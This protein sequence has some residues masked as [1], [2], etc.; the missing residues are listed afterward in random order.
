MIY[1]PAN[2]KGFTVKAVVKLPE[3]EQYPDLMF[4]WYE[5]EGGFKSIKKHWAEATT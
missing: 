4:S 5:H 3:G 2:K 1:S